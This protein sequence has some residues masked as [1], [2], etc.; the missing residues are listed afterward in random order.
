MRMLTAASGEVLGLGFSPAGDAVAA[1]VEYHGVFLW[2]LAAGAA[3]PQRLDGGAVYQ[4]RALD[5]SPDGRSVS[6]LGAG[7]LRAYD[8]DA[9][10]AA[11]VRLDARGQLFGVSRTADGRR[12]VTQHSFREP[13]L[14]GWR[15]ETGR[16]AREW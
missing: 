1:A 9:R 2:N 5:F 8:R 4:T 10:A 11:T 13:A 16:W 14:I 7:G 6:W 3:D 12:M 15:A